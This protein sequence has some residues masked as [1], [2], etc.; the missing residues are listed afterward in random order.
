MIR[1]QA[2]DIDATIAA[3]EAKGLTVTVTGVKVDR[4]A[5]ATVDAGKGIASKRKAKEFHAS[6]FIPPNCF[7][8]GI[9]THSANVMLSSAR[10]AGMRLKAQQR[11]AVQALLA[12]HWKVVGPW[13]EAARAGKQV[14]IKFIRLGGR[15]L[16]PHENLPMAMKHLLDAVC[17]VAGF[18]DGMGNLSVSYDQAESDRVGV[19]IWL[20][21]TE[22]TD[23]DTM[24]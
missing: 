24:A 13:G 15:R 12:P 21:P 7:L 17:S 11:A 18:D 10:G 22:G 14:G 5:T 23:T 16:D 1:I 9:A 20:T 4:P 2:T 6:T 8:L 3:W 19:Q